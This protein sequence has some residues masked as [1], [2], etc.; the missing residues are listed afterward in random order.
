MDEVDKPLLT[1][2][3]EIELANRLSE[4]DAI[5]KLDDPG[6]PEGPAIANA[7]GDFEKIFRKY[8]DELLPRVLAAKTCETLE[9]AL[10]DMNLE[11][12]EIV[13]HMWYPKYFRHHLLG[14]SSTPPW[15]DR[16]LR[17]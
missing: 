11:F 10:F 13:W 6:N 1:V 9:D 12:Q 2:K 15:I 4:C 14:E 7:L 8:L 5:R 17:A 3:G 16:S